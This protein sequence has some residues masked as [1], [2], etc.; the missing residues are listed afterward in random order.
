M[1]CI[2]HFVKIKP[3]IQET[4]VSYLVSLENGI[5]GSHTK[6]GDPVRTAI[7]VSESARILWELNNKAID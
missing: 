3:S 5:F 6:S 4:K 2:Q 1:S 7:H